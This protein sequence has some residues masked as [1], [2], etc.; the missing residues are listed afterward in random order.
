[1]HSGVDLAGHR[2]LEQHIAFFAD[3]PAYAF[4]L[5]TDYDSYG[6]CENIRFIQILIGGDISANHPDTKLLKPV[7]GLA[8]ISDPCNRNIFHRTR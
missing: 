5:I 6:S 1:M 4:I 8:E 2:K 7:Y 3:Q